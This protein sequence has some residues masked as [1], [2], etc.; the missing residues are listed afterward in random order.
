LEFVGSER[1]QWS[2][3]D[4]YLIPRLKREHGPNHRSVREARRRANELHEAELERLA[5]TMKEVLGSRD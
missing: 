3:I 1:P 2:S 4:E 5:V